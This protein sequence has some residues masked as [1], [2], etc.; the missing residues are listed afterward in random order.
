[1]IIVV[2]V[3]FISMGQFSGE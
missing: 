2:E 3:L 1:V